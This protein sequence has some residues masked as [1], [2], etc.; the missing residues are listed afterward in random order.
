MSHFSHTE[1]S[2]ELICLHGELSEVI[3]IKGLANK[4]S[5]LPIILN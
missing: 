3:P 5:M 2:N 4:P 1:N